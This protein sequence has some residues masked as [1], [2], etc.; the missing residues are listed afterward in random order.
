MEEFYL[1]NMKSEMERVTRSR[2]QARD[3]YNAMSRWYD[4]FTGS[5]KRFTDFGLQMLDV[6]PK[7][8]VLEIGCGT[9]HAL[10]EFTNT[11]GN[12]TGI[13]ISEKMLK[14]AH[15]K[16]EKK[17]AGLCQADGLH[18]PFPKEQFDNIFISFTLELFDTPEIPQVLNEIHRVLKGDGK[19]GI[20]S[21]A[22]QDT[23]T[24]R[25][26]EW[27]HRLMPN[28]VDCRP[29]YLQSAL[30]KAECQI[31]KSVIKK[32]WGLPVEIVVARKG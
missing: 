13:D 16:I 9:G 1:V 22:K 23:S 11:G 17:N 30:K 24:V 26:Y 32:M 25:I 7:E 29:I 10:V 4:L 5:E 19:L 28:I 8:S 12:I 15:R 31:L 18:L 6:Q 27:F 20:V 2:E 3:S 14:V 21:L